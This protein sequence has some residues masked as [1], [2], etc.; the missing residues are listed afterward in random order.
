MPE[1]GSLHVETSSDSGTL[2]GLVRAVLL[3]DSH[4][5]WHLVLSELDFLSTESGEGDVCDLVVGLFWGKG[6]S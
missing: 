5:T 3:S 6:E 1:S 4:E 2:Q